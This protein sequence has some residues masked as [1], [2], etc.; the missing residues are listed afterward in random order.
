MPGR[1]RTRCLT[2]PDRRIGQMWLDHTGHNSDRQH[3]SSTKAWRFDAVGVMRPIEGEADPRSAASTLSF[4]HPGKARLR[5]PDNWQQ[6]AAQTVRLVGDE[7]MYTP[8]AKDAAKT[9]QR[10]VI[11]GATG[12]CAGPRFFVAVLGASSYTFAEASWTQSLADW[13]A[14]HVNMLAFFGGVPRREVAPEIAPAVWFLRAATATF[15]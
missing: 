6:F 11:D 15:P 12:E 9:E 7:W 1:L 8:M 13:I 3:G 4:D 14:V 2:D 10:G 5:T